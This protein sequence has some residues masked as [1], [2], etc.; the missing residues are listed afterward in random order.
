MFIL[1]NL[2]CVSVSCLSH[3]LVYLNHLAY[4]IHLVHLVYLVQLVY[5]VFDIFCLLVLTLGISHM[6]SYCFIWTQKVWTLR[7]SLD[8][9]SLA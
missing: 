3:Y 5:L 9:L 7:L 6:Y 2:T 8:P 1:F 4:L